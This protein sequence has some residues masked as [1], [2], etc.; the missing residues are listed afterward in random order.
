MPWF[1]K[2][3]S[4]LLNQKKQAKPQWLHNPSKINGDNINNI[5]CE[6]N[7]QFKNKKKR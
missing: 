7:M 4:K 5:G 6:A 2:I 3:C 1:D